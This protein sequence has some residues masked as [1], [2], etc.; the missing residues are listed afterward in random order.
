MADDTN[1]ELVNLLSEQLPA[2]PAERDLAQRKRRQPGT[3]PDRNNSVLAEI[4]A[5]GIGSDARFPLLVR[6][7]ASKPARP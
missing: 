7:M 6:R 3:M 2:S 1:D 4:L 5:G